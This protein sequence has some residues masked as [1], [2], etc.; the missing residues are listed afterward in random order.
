[1]S[2]RNNDPLPTT[3]EECRLRGWNE[4]DIVLVTGDAYVDHPTFGVAVI[5]RILENK[6]YRVAILSQPQTDDGTDFKRFGRP[7]LF[8]GLS[9]GNLDS[10]VANY[11][12]HG[13]VREVDSFS[14]DGN[15][16]RTERRQKNNRRR[17]DRAVLKYAQC[18]RHAYPGVILVLGGVEASLRR[19]THF[20]YRQNAI[21]GSHLTDAK[22]NLLLYGMAETSVVEAAHR[23]ANN[24]TI[25][26]IQGSCIRLNDRE[27]ELFRKRIETSG[28]QLQELPSYSAIKTN[29][30]AF[31]EA[32][33]EI[34]RFARSRSSVLLAQ[35]QQAMWVVQ[36]PPA[37]P[38]ESFQLDSIYELP[39]TRRPHPTTP[40]V[41][42]YTMI[43]DS[44]TIVRGCPGN[45]SFC[46]ISR[47]QGP[48]VVSRS[49]DSIV[50]EIC[51]IVTHD[52][53]R[54]TISDLGGPT[55]NL[56]GTTCRIGSCKQH[57]CLYP[58]V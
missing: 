53:F 18:A 51:S 42:A 14:P 1:M 33:Q 21:R 8:F 49:V 35:R 15:P 30:K 24:K 52:D 16:W 5:G 19:F 37:P 11:S 47:H 46:A 26:D 10:I 22:A 41:P 38:L 57:D 58:E 36:L 6:G 7:L 3:L 48:A 40:N 20:D 50:R 29:S 54:G 12:A 44:V 9:A 13:R 55:A 28:Q 23:I 45:C 25:E 32:E 43:K 4:V 56:F 39:F 17:P 34:D 31:L 27:M 2:P